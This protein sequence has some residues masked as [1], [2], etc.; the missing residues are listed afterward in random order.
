MDWHRAKFVASVDDGD[1]SGK[2]RQINRLF[3]H[4]VAATDHVDLK[5]FKEGAVAGRAVRDAAADE[6]LL[7]GHPIDAGGRLTR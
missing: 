7:T 2:F 5:V 1:F 3:H 6:L 4:G